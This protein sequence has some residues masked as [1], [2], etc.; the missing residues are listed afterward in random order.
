MAISMFQ[1]NM[2]SISQKGRLP[3]LAR[4]MTRFSCSGVNRVG[5]ARSRLKLALSVPIQLNSK[6]QYS[7]SLGSG[8]TKNSTHE[9]WLTGERSLSLTA[10]R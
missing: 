8:E 10:R 4:R 7:V 5:W 9:S 2:P 1:V 3:Q 6:F